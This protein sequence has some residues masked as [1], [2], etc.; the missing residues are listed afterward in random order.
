MDIN[1]AYTLV[2]GKNFCSFDQHRMEIFGSPCSVLI[3]LENE[4]DGSLLMSD[5]LDDTLLKELVPPLKYRI[6][7]NSERKKLG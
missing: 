7:F 6:I 3:V 5:G 2:P 4:I 1:F